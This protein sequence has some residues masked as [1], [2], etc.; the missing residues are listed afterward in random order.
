[1]MGLNNWLHWVA[2]FLKY[3][4]FLFVSVFL[5]T[6]FYSIRVKDHGAVINNSDP[7]CI[8]L[9]FFM[10]SISTIALCFML[11]TFFSKGKC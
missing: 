6:V 3:L 4:I 10:F 9:F 7:T 8:F 1:M 11:S 5:M 2:W